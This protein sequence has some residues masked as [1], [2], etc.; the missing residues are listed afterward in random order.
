MTRE[1]TK[2][3]R[4][5]QFVEAVKTTITMGNTTSSYYSKNLLA[6]FFVSN[7]QIAVAN[8][9]ASCVLGHYTLLLDI[10]SSLNFK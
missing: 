2:Y 6:A 7:P 9:E 4:E 1:V 10:M 8:I 5:R 3:R